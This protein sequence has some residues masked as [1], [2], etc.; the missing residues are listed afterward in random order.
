MLCIVVDGWACRIDM[1]LTVGRE[2]GKDQVLLALLQFINFCVARPIRKDSSLPSPRL[3]WD[4]A[5][6]VSLLYA[7]HKGAF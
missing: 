6:H 7:M 2:V 3:S 5:C 1:C 4:H